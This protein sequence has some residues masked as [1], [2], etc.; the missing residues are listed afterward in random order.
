MTK[1]K[2][3]E[4]NPIEKAIGDRAKPKGNL[5]DLPENAKLT[6]LPQLP[7]EI[8]EEPSPSEMLTLEN[9]QRQTEERLQDQLPKEPTAFQ[10][11]QGV[12]EPIIPV[13]KPI[14]QPVTE[15]STPESEPPQKIEPVEN[16]IPVMPDSL[17]EKIDVGVMPD[18]KKLPPL[19]TENE[20]LAQ[21]DEELE[22]MLKEIN[23]PPAEDIELT[24]LR[25]YILEDGFVLATVSFHIMSLCAEPLTSP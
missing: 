5:A 2:K 9:L 24:A 14:P 10:I 18:A 25:K 21:Q 6:P 16:D 20:L 12:P 8:L 22:S 3:P 19:D 11:N 23:K 7:S 17:L 1:P 15:H 4:P 13:S